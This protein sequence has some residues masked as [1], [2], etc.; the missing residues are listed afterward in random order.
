M[1]VIIDIRSKNFAHIREV[2]IEATAPP[3]VGEYIEP[4]AELMEWTQRLPL[5]VTEARYRME[6]GG[7]SAMVTA[8][9]RGDESATHRLLLLQEQGWLEPGE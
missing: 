6:D 5:L 8:V 9:A 3:R 4:T 7:L 2:T 1:K